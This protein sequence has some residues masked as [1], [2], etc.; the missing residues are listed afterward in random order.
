MT[1][2][3]KIEPDVRPHKPIPCVTEEE[4]FDDAAVLDVNPL[5]A[6]EDPYGEP[7]VSNVNPFAGPTPQDVRSA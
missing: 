2:E 7:I 6:T 4:L 1:E 3:K 5:P